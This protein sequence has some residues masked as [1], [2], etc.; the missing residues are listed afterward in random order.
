[1]KIIFNPP[2]IN[3]ARIY[4]SWS[5]CGLY[6]KSEFWA[7][8]S[9]PI[10]NHIL[11]P[12]VL[13]EG[14]FPVI[15]GLAAMGEIEVHLPY[16]LSNGLLASWKAYIEAASKKCLKKE[17]RIKWVLPQSAAIN[18]GDLAQERA[19]DGVGVFFGGGAESLLLTARLLDEGLRPVLFSVTGQ[20]WAGSD[21][22][23]N[24]VKNQLDEKIS[25]ELNLQVLKIQTNLRSIVDD[26]VFKVYV[27]KDHSAFVSMMMSPFFISL[28]APIAACLGIGRLIHGNEKMSEDNSDFFCFTPD[29]AR[30]LSRVSSVVSY[31]SALNDLY[32]E[33][34]CRQLY[35]KYPSYAAYQYSCWKNNGRRWCHQC[36]TC[37]RYYILLKRFGLEPSLVEMN[38]AEIRKNRRRLIFSAARSDESFANETW[39]RMHRERQWITDAEARWFLDMVHVLSWVYHRI[40]QPVPEAFRSF[41]HL[42]RFLS[43]KTKT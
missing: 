34:V 30:L 11:T 18:T 29:A 36:E 26:R 6:S 3:G 7:E 42:T 21:P 27:K 33:D 41:L 39:P 37:L 1:M 10:Q 24:P 43:E 32:K 25:K 20:G 40:Y 23:L 4:Y 16:P 13:V 22:Q 17:S 31:E 8:Y 38:E 14:Y 9:Q 15:V 35:E 12:D 28:A 2:V 5:P 19:R